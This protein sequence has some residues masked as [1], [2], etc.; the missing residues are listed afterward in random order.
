MFYKRLNQYLILRDI[1]ES[2]NV[3]KL[4]HLK[5][6]SGRYYLYVYNIPIY[7]IKI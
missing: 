4:K 2:Y 6:K 7:N 1:Y 5:L 3:N